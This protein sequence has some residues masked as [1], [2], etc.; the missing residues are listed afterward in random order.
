MIFFLSSDQGS[1]A[2]TSR[3]IKPIIEFFFP[4]AAPDTFLLVHAF[5]RK[6]AH[7][8]EYGLLALVALR[9]FSN[10]SKPILRDYCSL[11]TFLLL[12]LIALTDETNQSFEA[13]RTSS[14]WDALLDIS[15]GGSVIII[16]YAIGKFRKKQKI[17][18]SD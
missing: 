8:T 2:E 4:S 14:A 12:V 6:C 16:F 9:T 5:I 3:F 17:N 18:I 7:F 11:W 13:S 1:S 10:S 15:G